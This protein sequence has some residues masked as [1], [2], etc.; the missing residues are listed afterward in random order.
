MKIEWQPISEYRGNPLLDFEDYLVKRVDV[1]EHDEE[2]GSHTVLRYT[3]IASPTLR[4]WWVRNSGFSGMSGGV[5]CFYIDTP[6]HFCQI[7]EQ[8][9]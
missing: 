4:G 2:E 3:H 5:A 1:F 9:Q 6:T 7:T 8:S